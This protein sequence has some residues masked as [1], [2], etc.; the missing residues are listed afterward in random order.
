MCNRAPPGDRYSGHPQAPLIAGPAIA[1]VAAGGAG[2]VLAGQIGLAALVLLG[3]RG[4]LFV[5]QRRLAATRAMAGSCNCA[6]DAGCNVG[7]ACELPSALRSGQ[8]VLWLIPGIVALVAFVWLL[9][10]YPSDYAGRAYAAHGGVYIAASL[11]WLW[12]AE[13]RAPDGWDLAGGALAIIAAALI[14]FAP[15][16]A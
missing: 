1:L 8:S 6:P 14:L 9:T 4:Y 5:R 7:D 10:L 16:G 2:L 15:R 12:L 3:A 11:L 13:H